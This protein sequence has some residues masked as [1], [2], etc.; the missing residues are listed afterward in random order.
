MRKKNFLKICQRVNYFK[1]EFL[2]DENEY[3]NF[4]EDP[5]S[6]GLKK[7]KKLIE[8]KLQEE[9]LN[10]IKDEYTLLQPEKFSFGRNN[11]VHVLKELWNQ[12]K[13]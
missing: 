1:L 2:I 8:K 10:N 7:V 11:Y 13:F 4:F 9:E 12:I 5:E 3:Y 6:N